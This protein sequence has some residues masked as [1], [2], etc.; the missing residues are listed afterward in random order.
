MAKEIKLILPELYPK[1]REAIFDPHR[2]A[3]IEAGTKTGKTLGCA[4][5]LVNNAWNIA[6]TKWWWTAPV[7]KQVEIG[8]ERCRTLMPRELIDVNYSKLI[9]EL[10]NGSLIE[11]RSGEKPDNLFG[12]AVDGGVV[13]EAS[14]YRLE[15]WYAFRTTLTQTQGTA[16]LIGNPKG[17]KNF[18]YKLCQAAKDPLQTELAYHHLKTEDNPFISSEEIQRAK[19]LLPGYV[20]EE[21]YMGI[22]QEDSAGV[23]R[24][25]DR[26][27]GATLSEP[28][29]GQRYWA[30]IDLAKYSNY[31]VVCVL[32]ENGGLVYF[33]RFH[34]IEWS[35]Q[36]K[37]IESVLRKYNNATALI[38]STGVGDPIFEDLRGME[39]D[40][41]GYKF[42]NESKKKLI[43]GLAI[44]IENQG[45]R[46]P[47]LPEL[48]AELELFEYQIT[49]SG[50]IQYS[51]PEGY[52]DDCV[53]ALSLARWARESLG[54]VA[55]VQ[56]EVGGEES[57]DILK[58]YN[59]PRKRIW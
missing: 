24:R 13:D 12:E 47:D 5:W 28:I 55:A 43:E 29:E 52:N 53:I 17:R 16:R 22:A 8:F 23:F 56:N 34:E 46:F 10:P 31:T 51:A 42:T 7:Y 39:L 50:N 18:F 45:I 59:A 36:K 38:D 57:A 35:L 9:I 4:I 3:L 27:F 30:G 44:A 41:E 48:V 26:C 20:F 6:S 15:S 21:L 2:F 19:R 14:R 11:G 32:D 37:R 58:H 1:Q 25:I 33:D 54:L 49:P 40:I